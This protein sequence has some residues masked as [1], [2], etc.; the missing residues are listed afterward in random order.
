MDS[1]RASILKHTTFMFFLVFAALVLPKEITA[2]PYIIG[3]DISWTLQDEAGGATYWDN[4][5]QKDLLQILKEHK[6]NFI[7]LRTFVNPCASGGYAAG[8]R[9]CWCDLAHTAKMAKRVKA[10]SMGFL[11]DFHMSDTWASIGEQHVPSAWA[12][13]NDA[14]LQAHAYEYTK[15]CVD[16]LVKVGARPDMVQVGNEINSKMSGVSTSNWSRFAALVN[17]G[18]RG[19]REVDPTIKIVIHHGRPREDGNFLPWVKGIVDSKIDFDFI[20]GSTYGTTN[21]GADW[22]DQFGRV[23]STYNKAVMSLEYTGQRTAL[24]NDVMNGLPNQMGMGSF[25]WEPTR[26]SEYTM[27][28]R[29]GNR[30]TS[31]SRLDEVAAVATKFDATLYDFVKAGPVSINHE[32]KGTLRELRYHPST[33]TIHAVISGKDV[34]VEL[35]SMDGRRVFTK[36]ISAGMDASD[37]KL[38]ADCLNNGNY[39]LKTTWHTISDVRKITI[40]K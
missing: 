29:S 27:F 38:P 16:S 24:V 34:T 22:R 12:N 7:R 14:Q 25:V 26:Y 31:N 40:L 37:I 23:I 33:F 2:R 28:D 13:D 30:Y 32:S 6:F 4:G 18:I 15:R 8:A 39:L 36:M 1:L 10:A 20:G 5:V 19:V 11:L 9:E 35:F 17:A 3:A 21:N